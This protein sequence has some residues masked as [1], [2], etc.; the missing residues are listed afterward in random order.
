MVITTPAENLEESLTGLLI[1]EARYCQL[2]TADGEVM[3]ITQR[4]I[5]AEDLNCKVDVRIQTPDGQ[6]F[7]EPAIIGAVVE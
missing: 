3:D 7:E 2:C 4:D 5:P 1:G 6:A